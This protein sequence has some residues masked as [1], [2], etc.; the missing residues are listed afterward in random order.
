MDNIHID[1]PGFYET[2]SAYDSLADNQYNLPVS[3]S[4]LQSDPEKFAIRKP[5]DE[6]RQFLQFKDS[7]IQIVKGAETLSEF[8][9]LTAFQRVYEY[10]QLE[11]ILPTMTISLPDGEITTGTILGDLALMEST[12]LIMDNNFLNI[13]NATVKDYSS[14]LI[15]P[16]YHLLTEQITAEFGFYLKINSDWVYANKFYLLSGHSDISNT[17]ISNYLQEDL[18]FKIVLFR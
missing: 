9:L 8:D 18:K 15:I 14:I 5:L 10:V 3:A 1:E 6:T 4:S 11:M 13:A 16:Q 12:A 17:I 7:K 2:G